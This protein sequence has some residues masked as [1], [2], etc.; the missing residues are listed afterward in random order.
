MSTTTKK[1][2]ANT[3]AATLAQRE[4]EALE[5][6]D[7][8]RKTLTVEREKIAAFEAAV[9][10]ATETLE[11]VE[12]LARKGN[13]DVTGLA[14]VEARA[15]LE[16]AQ[17]GHAGATARAKRLAEFLGKAHINKDV[18][19]I[20]RDVLVQRML[21]GA[22]SYATFG[23]SGFVR[24]ADR[25]DTLPAL[26]V[27]QLD[28]G[29][30][31]DGVGEGKVRITWHRSPLHTRIN[32]D[33]VRAAL[34]AAG[35]TIDRSG[36]NDG[37]SMFSTDDADTAEVVLYNVADRTPVAVR[38][39]SNVDGWDD[40]FAWD[41]A[42]AHELIEA[43]GCGA[44]IVSTE[45]HGDVRMTLVRLSIAAQ[46]DLRRREGYDVNLPFIFAEVVA[47][48]VDEVRPG[49]GRCTEAKV[50]PITETG[51]QY[52]DNGSR[53]LTVEFTYVARIA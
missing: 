39:L 8:A 38:P 2:T 7:Q 29:I 12:A 41:Y 27:T 15:G 10:T 4:A 43:E 3:F 13:G 22:T 14:L 37:L 18:A 24:D 48:R 1:K 45:E 36:L 26:V 21:P 19:E 40:T 44:R 50:V 16:V 25:P 42:R 46:V 35:F 23:T 6:V 9:E 51:P 33:Q 49:A 5:K 28:G 31:A 30:G 52:L 47:S 17:M 32:A 20:V 53:V 34:G 11:D